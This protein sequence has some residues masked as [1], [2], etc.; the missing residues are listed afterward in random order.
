MSDGSL[1]LD[2]TGA[3]AKQHGCDWVSISKLG[4][5][6]CHNEKP[7]YRADLDVWMN[8]GQPKGI[9]LMNVPSYDG[10]A[11]LWSVKEVAA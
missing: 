5:M 6:Y 1:F 9:W 4:I 7:E 8:D 3:V 11:H 10:G 2:V